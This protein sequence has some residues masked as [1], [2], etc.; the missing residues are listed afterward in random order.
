MNSNQSF[1][2][3]I[4]ALR[5]KSS[6]PL[7]VVAAAVEMDSTLLSKI[8]RGERFPNEP[9]IVR[10]A[11]YFNVPQNELRTLVIAEKIVAQYGHHAATIR[12]MKIVKERAGVSAKDRK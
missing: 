3:T 1:G 11:K 12:A 10:F 9:Q 2:E 7:R 6:E 8:E 5:K 4:R